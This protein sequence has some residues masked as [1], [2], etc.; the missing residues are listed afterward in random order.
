[1][2]MSKTKR[3]IRLEMNSPCSEHPSN[4]SQNNLGSFCDQCFKQVIDF[5]RMTDEQI[6]AYFMKN[7]GAVCGRFVPTQLKSYDIPEVT[8]IPSTTGR[9]IIGSF[10]SLATAMAM[11][12]S[13][14]P[15]SIKAISIE[16]LARET[17]EKSSDVPMVNQDPSI[18]KGMVSSI[19]GA[20]IPNVT[21]R[22]KG[23]DISTTTDYLGRYELE[24]PE[25]YLQ[26][27]DLTFSTSDSSG[28][29][30]DG[31]LTIKTFQVSRPGF[32]YLEY[33]EPQPAR[34]GGV[35]AY[36]EEYEFRTAH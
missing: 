21:V 23:T 6:V 9:L 26:G 20:G 29:F 16:Q 1:M 14:S 18:A 25:E 34:I 11:G 30:I 28:E 31:E 3:R 10:I 12:L 35:R 36:Y 17:Q 4:M 27:T 32:I 19:G 7:R 13:V 33:K 22:L 24:I 15:L 5:T 8:K 2:A